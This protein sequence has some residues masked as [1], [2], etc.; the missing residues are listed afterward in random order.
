MSVPRLK[1]ALMSPL[2][3][4]KFSP[5]RR[6]VGC[7]QQTLS[8]YQTV[9]DIMAGKIAH[10][11]RRP[12][13]A[14]TAGRRTDVGIRTKYLAFSVEGDHKGCKAATSSRHGKP[15]Q[16]PTHPPTSKLA[17]FANFNQIDSTGGSYF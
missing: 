12:N 15:G 7:C 2:V 5:H 11:S 9:Q 14:G 4:M 6:A 17:N 3:E 16:W 13:G 10:V 8:I 1:I